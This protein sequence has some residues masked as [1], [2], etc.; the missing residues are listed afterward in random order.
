MISFLQ[1][2]ILWWLKPSLQ[3]SDSGHGADRL[4][5]R[6][7]R[8]YKQYLL[9]LCEELLRYVSYYVMVAAEGDSS[10]KALGY[11]TLSPVN[12]WVIGLVDIEA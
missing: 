10:H 12:P 11:L 4:V 9:T 1:S 3:H 8:G 7:F 2:C 6:V 5:G